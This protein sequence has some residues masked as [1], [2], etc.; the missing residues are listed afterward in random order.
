[1]QTQLSFWE[2]ETYFTGI[3]VVI[4]GSGIVGLNAA[5]HLK[6]KLPRLNILVAE[7]GA[8]PSGATSKN[9]GF[10]CFGSVSELA[11]D[12]KDR[13]EDAVFS[14]VE[15]RFLGLKRLRENLG[16]AAIDFH[17]W[18]GYEVFDDEKN[19][20]ECAEKIS[21]FNARLKDITGRAQTYSIADEKIPAFGFSGVKHMILNS[22]EGQI[23]TGMALEAMLTK[24]RNAGIR[25]LNGLFIED[26]HEEG[27]RISI[28]CGNGYSFT[29]KKLLI[30]TNGFAKQFLP[31]EDVQ[32]A[33][34]QVL[35]T[36]PIEN[37]KFR[38]TF[39]Y[40][41]GYYYFRNIGERVLF[42][43]GRNL[44]FK[45][46]T[47][48]EHSLTAGIQ[49]KLDEL[50]RTMI[51]PGVNYSVEQRWAGTMG[52]GKTKSPVVKKVSAA[53][54]CAVRMGGMGVALGSLTGEEAAELVAR[55][56]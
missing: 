44:D 31:A 13:S 28:R 25:V 24:A 41:K 27:N 54:F 39:H 46:E 15:K 11:D 38:G 51:L 2:K 35:V 37:L 49:Q 16:D 32:P 7:Q 33:R 18:G 6:K 36:S 47:T 34:A 1:M 20:E 12:L 5:L 21:G 43:G 9:A 26:I 10:A 52:V 48:T 23:N 55:E 30:C 4:A 17:E 50:L 56:M 3:D 45:G 8:L 29:A 40:D 22:A 53:I 42:G 14:L 19:Y